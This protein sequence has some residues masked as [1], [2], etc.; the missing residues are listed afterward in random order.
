MKKQRRH[1]SK[2]KQKIIPSRWSAETHNFL[3][4][5]LVSCSKREKNGGSSGSIEKFYLYN[6]DQF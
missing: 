4:F 1:G 6:P 3:S 2:Y 5:A